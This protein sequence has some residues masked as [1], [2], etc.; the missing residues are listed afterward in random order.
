M[1]LSKSWVIV[2]L[3]STLSF[4]NYPT[5][6]NVKF[7]NIVTLPLKPGDAMTVTWTEVNATNGTVLNTLPFN[8]VLRALTGQKYNVQNNV[9]QEQLTVKVTIP[10]AATGGKHSWYADYTGSDGLTGVSSNQ[11]N[12]TGDIV[13]TT[14]PAQV[15]TSTSAITS[16]PTDAGHPGTGGSGG[17]GLSGGALGGII[18]GVIGLLLIVALIFFFRHRRLVRERSEATR[19]EDTKERYEDRSI[20]GNSGHGQM[21]PRDPPHSAAHMNKDGMNGQPD[22]R[23]I[24]PN[25]GNMM[26]HHSNSSN[27]FEGPGEAMM[28]GG[29]AGAAA[30]G[31]MGRP[32]SDSPS[33]SGP[34]SL[35]PGPAS[36]SP[37]QQHHQYQPPQL[38]QQ[39]HSPYGPPGGPMV[40]GGGMHPHQNQQHH[41]A[42]SFGRPGN[43]RDSFE[44]EPESAY[45]PSQPAL[46]MNNNYHQ[47][48]PVMRNNSNPMMRGGPPGPNNG[49]INHQLQHSNSGRSNMSDPRLQS[50]NNSRNMSPHPH[51]PFQDP[52]LM[53]AATGAGMVGAAAHHHHQQ[54]QQQQQ[55]QHYQQ[56][57]ASPANMQRQSSQNRGNMPRSQSPMRSA[58]PYN[59][60]IEMQPLE[61]QQH[62]YEQQQ[63]ALQRQQQEQEQRRQQEQEQQQRQKQQQKEQPF[64]VQQQQ[65][66]A[67]PLSQTKI[68]PTQ[69][70]TPIPIGSPSQHN[71]KTEIDDEGM[72]VYNGYRDTIFGAYAAHQGD[73]DDD[74]ESDHE[75]PMPI[76][77][78]EAL[79]KIQREK[80]NKS[81]DEEEIRGGAGV[82]RKKSVKFT[83]IPPSGPIVVQHV[84]VNSPANG[85]VTQQQPPKQ[86]QQQQMYHSDQDEEDDFYEDEEE[87]IKLRM[88]EAEVPSP[89]SSH[90]R[91]PL[92]NTSPGSSPLNQQQNALSPVRGFTSPTTQYHQ[93]SPVHQAPQYQNQYHGQQ[94]FVA[95][96]LPT[97]APAPGPT[98]PRGVGNGFYEDVLAAVDNNAKTLP[99]APAPASPSSHRAPPPPSALPPQHQQQQQKQQSH[100]QF[101]QQQHIPAPQPTHMQPVHQ[102]IFGAPSPR[103]NPAQLPG[104]QSPL[105]KSGSSG[106]LSPSTQNKPALSPRSAARPP[107]KSQQQQQ[108]QHHYRDADEDAFYESSLL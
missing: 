98:S 27:P 72:P 31:A 80:H 26:M 105:S 20:G 22:S 29:V 102:E 87:D 94:G 55:Q 14:V 89:S 104:S 41:P 35:S 62:Q 33:I 21:G 59:R 67:T 82:E 37:R 34:T 86:Q 23:S 43:S 90:S 3:F 30:A 56:G 24:H 65:P 8:L 54:Q 47:G 79:H 57:R 77:P 78:A 52:E 91:P 15:A 25:D 16:T 44:S 96:P 99:S 66:V 64:P 76:V 9:P 101:V 5:S 18:G 60:E 17:G 73:E 63:R 4:L 6:A 13:P 61:I 11:F 92:I 12:I 70:A 19:L 49:N 71:D 1:T 39:P 74:E 108:Q 88:M 100:Q 40:G 85:P 103:I 46:Q 51:N 106:S 48:G 81:D 50:G 83:G 32:R 107:A 7:N 84:V 97:S 42:G 93:A 95:P 45:D 38:N 2:A 75:V 53:A 68:P 69:P 58:S 36:L 28:M 10:K